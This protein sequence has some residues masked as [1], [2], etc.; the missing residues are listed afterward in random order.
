MSRKGSILVLV[1][2][3][4]A[5]LA[6]VGVSFAYRTGLGISEGRQE[7][8]LAKLRSQAASAAAIVTAQLVENTNDF[9]HPG[10]PWARQGLKD[11]GD[12]LDAWG[13]DL[14]HS[15][16]GPEYTVKLT[17]IDENRKLNLL[18][19]SSKQLESIGLS[20][21]QVQ[22]LTDW[23]D[24]DESAGRGGAES[25]FY[26]RW[27]YRSKNLPM[28]ELEEMLL[29]AGLSDRAFYGQAL[30]SPF[31]R[32]MLAENRSRAADDIPEEAPETGLVEL[33]RCVG[34]YGINLNTAPEAVLRC[35]PITPEAVG[36]ILAYRRFD[37]DSSGELEDHVFAKVE[38]IEQLQGLAP[39][40]R[41]VLAEMGRF[42]SD[43]FRIFVVARHEPSGL[44]AGL[45]V[46]VDTTEGAPRVV[47]WKESSGC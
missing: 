40:D 9:D 29:V 23:M 36:Q 14:Q 35:L 32:P 11:P 16:R 7:A 2:F 34:D 45:E 5:I 18:Y 12:Y 8:V 6:L 46:L 38:D 22:A 43:H 15:A 26:A 37:P 17:V 3:V 27:G 47:R 39:A 41:A 30:A 42:R 44:E 21:E 19:A 10:E 33:L 1:L 31:C 28:I 24:E 4:L 13:T 25:S 20:P